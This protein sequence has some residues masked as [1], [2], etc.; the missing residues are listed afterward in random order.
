[1]F[2]YPYAS[3]KAIAL[4]YFVENVLLYHRGLTE[5]FI[6][7]L[8]TNK[9]VD[10]I[11]ELHI[12]F[13]HKMQNVIYNKREDK[14]NYVSL[15]AFRD[16]THTFIDNNV[17]HKKRCSLYNT[18]FIPI[19]QR[20]PGV[21][22]V[23]A[24]APNL[25]SPFVNVQYDGEI[26]GK[27]HLSFYKNLDPIQSKV[28]HDL[29][30]SFFTCY[31]ETPILL[32][33]PRWMRWNFLVSNT[34]NDFYTRNE[35]LRK[36][37]TNDVNLNYTVQGPSNVKEL[38]ITRIECYIKECEL[39]K[40]NSAL[41]KHANTVKEIIVNNGFNLQNTNTVL[42]DCQLYLLP[43]DF[44]EVTNCLLTGD[45]ALGY[46]V[47]LSKKQVIQYKSGIRNIKYLYDGLFS[48]KFEAKHRTTFISYLPIISFILAL[49]GI[50]LRFII[51]K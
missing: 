17:E 48:I 41:K 42:M 23:I 12:L 45:V 36:R 22:K 29:G 14:F 26:S 6:D 40:N 35:Y 43:Q 32:N 16:I 15:G 27:S 20:S 1:M 28:L 2:I 7:L 18:T 33:E 38:F 49:I 24:D 4:D 30:F 39:D 50:T 9:S 51:R 31:F 25:L 46:S 13:P 37:L 5:I 10:P 21:T 47:K 3:G 19:Q 34:S 11:H 44:Q 8:V